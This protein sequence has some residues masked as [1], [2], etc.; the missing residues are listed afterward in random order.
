[1]AVNKPQSEQQW[2]DF[3][4]SD[5]RA[6]FGELYRHYWPGLFDA[7][8]KRTRDREQCQDILQNVFA[9]L[10]NRRHTSN[11]E[12]LGAYLHTAVKFQ[13]YKHISRRPEKAAFLDSFDEIITSPIA[14]DDLLKEKE[15]QQ[16]INLWLAALPERRRRIFI[17]HYQEEL[18]TREIADQLGISQN[19]VQAQLYTA[20]QAL[21]SRL[22]HFLSLA[23]IVILSQR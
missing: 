16:V 18:S 1:M 23:A 11:I 19:T 8:Y 14:A 21:R 10:W 20:S 15:I 12:N 17:M 13:V 7:A 5:D 9:D 2:L 6:A 3:L 22:A 4:K